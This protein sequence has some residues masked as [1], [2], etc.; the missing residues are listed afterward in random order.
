MTYI[1]YFY[2]SKG[3]RCIFIFWKCLHEASKVKISGSKPDNLSLIPRAHMNVFLQ[4]FLWLLKVCCGSVFVN[5]SSCTRVRAQ[6]SKCL[7]IKQNKNSPTWKHIKQQKIN[8]TT[9]NMSGEN[10]VILCTAR[11]QQCTATP[12]AGFALCSLSVHS[13]NA[14]AELAWQ[15]GSTV[16]TALKAQVLMEYLLRRFPVAVWSGTLLLWHKTLIQSSATSFT[17]A[18]QSNPVLHTVYITQHG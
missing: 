2:I 14:R 3:Y 12:A 17:K 6:L 11:T 1:R 7:K 9:K 18:L 10:R 15:A 8:K 13:H 5:T 16:P 4:V